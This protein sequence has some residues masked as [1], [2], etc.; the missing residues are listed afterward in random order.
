MN[1]LKCFNMFNGTNLTLN[2]DLALV[3]TQVKSLLYIV[4]Q[5]A[6]ESSDTSMSTCDGVRHKPGH[7]KI[8]RTLAIFLL[9]GGY[10]ACADPE[11]GGQGV[12]TPPPLENHKNIVFVA[13]LVPIPLKSLS[14][15]A[16]FQFWAIIGTPAKRHFKMA[17][18]WQTEDGP[19]IVVFG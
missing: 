15:Q 8:N 1:I 6:R 17:F 16:S 12:Q 3:S 9:I 5:T 18:R 4:G 11:G 7:W 19:L 2:S 14:Y 10:I 13:I